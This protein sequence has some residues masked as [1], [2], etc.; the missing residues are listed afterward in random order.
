MLHGIAYCINISN[1]MN[2]VELVFYTSKLN[3]AGICT[4]EN[5]AQKYINTLR[6]S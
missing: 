5:Y 6:T 2:S 3:T 1:F 4:C